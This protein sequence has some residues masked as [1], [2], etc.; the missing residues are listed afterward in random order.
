[1]NIEKVSVFDDRLLERRPIAK[2]YK[3]SGATSFLTANPTGG[4]PNNNRNTYNINLV[5]SSFMDRKPLIS[6]KWQQTIKVSL[7][8]GVTANNTV[9]AIVNGVN[10]SLCDYPI[11]TALLGNATVQLNNQLLGNFDMSTYAKMLLRLGDVKKNMIRTLGPSCPELGFAKMSDANFTASSSF[12]NFNDANPA[13][14]YV[15]NGAWNN[16]TI[17]AGPL[18]DATGGPIDATNGTVS[19][20]DGVVAFKGTANGAGIG[21]NATCLLTLTCT[22]IEPLCLPPFLHQEKDTETALY[23]IYNLVIDL[24]IAQNNAQRALRLIPIDTTKIAFDAT[25]GKS[26]DLTQPGCYMNILY[27][28]ISPPI[29]MKLPMSKQLLQT[30]SLQSTFKNF[31][32]P[33]AGNTV[34]VEISNVNCSSMPTRILLAAVP[35][36]APDWSKANYYYPINSVAADLGGSRQGILN[37]LT[38]YRLY[39]MSSMSGLDQDWLSFS[40]SANATAFN[41][42]GTATSTLVSL[43]SGPVV[44]IPSM[45]GFDL[46]PDIATNVAGNFTFRFV[47]SVG[48]QG[49]DATGTQANLHVLYLFDQYIETDL[50]TLNVSYDRANLSANDVLGVA[51]KQT[52]STE[53]PELTGGVLGA[54]G[55]KEHGND[56]D[57]QGGAM[58]VGGGLHRRIKRR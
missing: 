15:P 28:Q 20:A 50:Q 3:G 37:N 25:T 54:M 48:N 16:I 6:A 11:N 21:A 39:Q 38:Q 18:L 4:S 19:V 17:T 51:P 26:I 10:L 27:S 32:L 8:T 52:I 24:P 42:Q 23:G 44:M 49:V 2:M 13:L 55:G 31:P 34:Q 1:M 40:G 9:N 36:T 47:V 58:P 5:S 22:S 33:A 43:V 45:F 56:V 41:T 7:P 46:P 12:S 14:G 53:R 35:A 29:D 30:W 57:Q